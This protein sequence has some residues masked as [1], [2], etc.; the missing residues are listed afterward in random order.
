[1]TIFTAVELRWYPEGQHG[2]NVCDLMRAMMELVNLYVADAIATGT[3][4]DTPKNID[5][6]ISR[7]VDWLHSRYG[8]PRREK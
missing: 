1:M 7:A 8:S 3:P 6:E 5:A 4:T 2:P